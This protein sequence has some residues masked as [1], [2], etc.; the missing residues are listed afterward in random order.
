MLLLTV[1]LER[2]DLQILLSFQDQIRGKMPP[3]WR[4]QMFIPCLW[5]VLPH[6]SYIFSFTHFSNKP[7]QLVT[8]SACLFVSVKLG[9]FR[10]YTRELGFLLIYLMFSSIFFL[11]SEKGSLDDAIN[12]ATSYIGHIDLHLTYNSRNLIWCENMIGFMLLFFDAILLCRDI[13]VE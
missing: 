5:L 7:Y 13:N 12:L 10:V 2:D 6:S 1:K 8:L 11:N 3:F 4:H 9:N